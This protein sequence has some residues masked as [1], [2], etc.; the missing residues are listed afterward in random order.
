MH[1]ESKSPATL[2]ERVERLRGYIADKHPRFSKDAADRVVRDV[3]GLWDAPTKVLAKALRTA[4][5]TERV[6][7]AHQSSLQAAAKLQGYA[8]YFDVPEP[9]PTLEVITAGDGLSQQ[10]VA[11]WRAA[12][13]FVLDACKTW[14]KANA[15]HALMR[16]DVQAHALAI[17][18]IAPAEDGSEAIMPV[19]IVRPAV[20]GP[21]LPGAASVFERVRRQVEETHGGVLDGI[22]L[23]HFCTGT[24][25]A[26]PWFG[27][28]LKDADAPNSE[29]VLLRKDH[30]HDA[31]S[32]FEIAR[33]DEVACW[34]QLREALEGDDPNR[35]VVG[36]TGA[37]VCGDARYV[38]E[39]AT[40]RPDD[41]ILG[42]ARAILPLRESTQLL[43]RFRFAAEKLAP[44]AKFSGTKRLAWL[45][46]PPTQCM[47]DAR[48]VSRALADMGATWAS[49]CETVQISEPSLEAPVDLGLVMTLGEFLKHTDP[50]VMVRR[51]ARSEMTAIH[52]DQL[53]RALMPRLHHI[54]YSMARG[55]D[56][57]QHQVVRE[58]IENFS[59]SL[60][61]RNGL[62][63][64]E[65]QLPDLVYASD[66]DE[67]RVA[68]A[69]AGM[70]M[71]IGLMPF[72][73]PIPSEQ[74]E[75]WPHLSPY[76]FG[77]SLYLEI[78]AA[79]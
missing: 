70:T 18:G 65:P 51:P 57:T 5:G 42:M 77:L 53:L 9:A 74:R 40:L 22:A 15:S 33:G 79:A 11:S 29:L 61:L 71:S 1:S 6:A 36:E 41:A 2:S 78:D 52:D 50:A 30:P 31:E 26:A 4:L 8:T 46:E 16:L 64:V 73:K 21:W 17:H 25:A 72:L 60:A 32:G 23:A 54:R 48:R 28:E 7:I 68:L 34:T 43:R 39:I 19:V 38:W 14:L 55:L 3:Q 10:P 63:P 56:P 66:G 47:L 49:F 62:F 27:T 13:S 58:A 59:A 69:D 45:A 76:A 24:D 67:L 75:T 37:W 35:I 20:T 12:A 44:R